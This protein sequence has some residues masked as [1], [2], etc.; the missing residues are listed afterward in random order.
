MTTTSKLA[1]D[2]APPTVTAEVPALVR[3]DDREREQLAEMI[4]QPSLFYWNG[5]QTAL[6]VERFRQRYPLEYVMCCSSGTAAL[7]VAVS[8]AGVGPGD[9]VITTPVTDMG[10]V[11]GILY[12]QGVPVFADLEPDRYNLDVA[13]VADKITPR[14]KAILAV[15]LGGN[16]SDMGGL[17]E[18]A[19]RHDLV[20]IEDCAQAWGATYRGRPVGTIGH[21]GC[22]SLNDFKHIGCGDGGIVASSDDR[23]GPR[24]QVFADKAY[25][26]LSS[27]RDVEVLAPNYRISEPQSAVAAVQMTRLEEIV[28][29]RAGLS[30]LLSDRL[31]DIPGI[32]VRRED[33]EDF[34]SCW[35]YMF[36]I[37]PA[38]LTCDR[39]RFA[40]ALAAEGCACWV[41]YLETPIY[42]YPLFQTERFFAG[43]W[44]AKELGLTT[45]DYSKVNLPATEAI[46][47]SAVNVTIRE[48]MTAEYIEQS[49]EAIAKVAAFYRR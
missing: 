43:R 7:H 22:Y 16:P 33:P 46:C 48:N 38:E 18:L 34:C 6:L 12:Q 44:P 49:A 35:F 39:D 9:E 42:R 20:L 8:A 36:R 5:P 25:D 24:L 14:T 19:D 17:K 41:G 47:R 21:I 15:H 2:G 29:K 30:R 40:A 26:R 3:W 28:Q 27:R 45:M 37:D 11:I 31:A 32:L 10:T 13:D 4:D 23:F 1:I